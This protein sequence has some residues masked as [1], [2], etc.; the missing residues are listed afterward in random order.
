MISGDALKLIKQD[1][2]K[3]MLCMNVLFVIITRIH[4]YKG[5]DC[6]CQ[7]KTHIYYK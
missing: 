7:D 6:I 1:S 5:Q 4:L 2:E 3:S